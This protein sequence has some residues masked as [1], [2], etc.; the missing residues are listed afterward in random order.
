VRRV[1]K[2][3][4]LAEVMGVNMSRTLGMTGDCED[5]ASVTAALFV[6]LEDSILSL[7][8]QDGRSR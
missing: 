2:A 1:K 6:A 4:Q 8:Q 5:R 3:V 7:K